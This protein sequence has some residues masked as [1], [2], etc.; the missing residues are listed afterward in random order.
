MKFLMDTFESVKELVNLEDAY[1]NQVEDIN[2]VK[3]S[4]EQV[5]I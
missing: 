1:M 5:K 4:L 2:N 3:E